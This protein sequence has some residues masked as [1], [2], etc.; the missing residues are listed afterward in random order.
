[1][2]SFP[3]RARSQLTPPCAKLPVA[4]FETL[5][6]VAHESYRTSAVTHNTAYKPVCPALL[7]IMLYRIAIVVCNPFVQLN[8]TS[9]TRYLAK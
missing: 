3:Q 2:P 8:V 9:L 7:D 5:V 1:M 4:A 6:T